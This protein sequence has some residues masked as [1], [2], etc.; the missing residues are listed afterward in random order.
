MVTSNNTVIK[1][2]PTT[3]EYRNDIITYGINNLYPQI[4]EEISL[5]SPTTKSSIKVLSKFLSGNG[6]SENGDMVINRLGQTLN[7]ILKIIRT[8]RAVFDG[9]SLHFNVNEIGGITEILPVK[10]KNVRYGVPDDYGFVYD[11]KLN[12]N[13][14]KHDPLYARKREEVQTFPLWS[15]RNKV[16]ING[17][18]IEDFSGYVYYWTPTPNEYPLATFDSVLDSAQSNGEIQIFELSRIMNGF[19]GTSLFKYPSKIAGDKERAK[20]TQDLHSLTGSANAGAVMLMEVPADFTG[21]LIEQIPANNDDR[22]FELTNETSQARIVSNF[23][24]PPLLLG[25]QPNGGMFNQE[26]MEDSYVYMNTMTREDRASISEAFNDIMKNWH[27]GAVSVGEILENEFK[28]KTEE[29]IDV[30]ST[31]EKTTEEAT[32]ETTEEIKKEIIKENPEE[33]VKVTEEK[34]QKETSFNG[35]QISSALDIINRVTIGELS[36]D[37]GVTALMEFLRLTEE[38]A[39]QLLKK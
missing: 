30:E 5:R 26:Q 6:F 37:Q 22:L 7:D 19:L 25:I 39:K 9:W 4:V 16:D 38:T 18:S 11:V 32:P 12:I 14:E 33:A 27:T 3:I 21:E 20:I 15:A 31:P 10:F 36:T 34:A 8:D 2:L 28:V 17:E 24:I 13:W 23:Q 1:R 29:E 35:A